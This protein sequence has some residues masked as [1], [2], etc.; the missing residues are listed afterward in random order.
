M[1]SYRATIIALMVGSLATFI[2]ATIPYAIDYLSP[3]FD[4]EYELIGPITIND[5]RVLEIKIINNGK[6]L[7]PNVKI[8][9][10][11]SLSYTGSKRKAIKNAIKI[12]T[13]TNYKLSADDKHFIISLGDILPKEKIELSVLSD[14][15]IVIYYGITDP[16]GL[17]IKSDRNLAEI[18]QPGILD[19]LLYPM[20]FWVMVF[21][22][23]MVIGAAIYETYWI[24]DEQRIERI[25]LELKKLSNRKKE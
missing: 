1:Q 25:D 16:S 23:T 5:A 20:S 13:E 6:K 21:F 17:K 9:I 8:F 24:S 11:A 18:Q 10:R 2:A 3:E 7:E 15:I 12:D 14:K 19:E 4:L 22:F